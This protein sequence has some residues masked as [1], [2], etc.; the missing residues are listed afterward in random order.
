MT[1]DGSRITTMNRPAWACG[2][3]EV[4][5]SGSPALSRAP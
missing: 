2:Y 3:R 1:P 5:M 4:L